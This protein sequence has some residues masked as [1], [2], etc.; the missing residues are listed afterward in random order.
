LMVRMGDPLIRVFAPR[1]AIRVV[2]ILPGGEIKNL[3]F[4]EESKEWQARFD[5]P[6]HSEETQYVMQ[7]VTV[8]KNGN[9]L[10]NRFLTAWT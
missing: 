2:A 4:D 10:L 6:T 8:L 3:H 5:V 7:L 9:R 1:D